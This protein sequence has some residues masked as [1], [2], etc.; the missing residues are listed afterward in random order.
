LK[1][2]IFLTLNILAN[3]LLFCKIE[4]AGYPSGGYSNETEFYAGALAYIRYRPAQ[5]DTLTSKNIFYVSTTYS[6]KKQFNLLFQPTI[7]FQDGLYRSFSELQ[8]KKWPSEFYGIGM[9]SNK[10]IS[11]KYTSEEIKFKSDFSRILSDKWELALCYEFV[12]HQ[13]LKLEDNELLASGNILGSQNSSASG[14]GFKVTF[15]SSNSESYPAKGGLYSFQLT[16]FS[17]YIGS[18]HQYSRAT[19]DLRKYVELSHQHILAFQSYFSSINGDVPFHQLNFLNDSMRAIT[20]NL[21]IDQNVYVFRM[22]DRF[23]YWNDGFKKRFGLVLFAEL[24]EVSPKFNKF[25]LKQF[26]FNYGVG[27][28]YSFFLDNRMNARLD[29]G[30]GEI[31]AS[32][33]MATGEVF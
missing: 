33:S 14:A 22:E 16:R 11:E 23:F 21:Y 18:D 28:R 19:L 24:G 8:F 7:Y 3:S 26:Q 5:F 10:D 32:I 15:N 31:K 13:I 17:K 29:I 6:Q 9:N 27:F 2:L 20:S 30:F 1:I 12:K 4:I 25:N